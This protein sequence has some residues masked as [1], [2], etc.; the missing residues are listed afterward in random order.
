[1]GDATGMSGGAGTGTLGIAGVG[2]IGG[3]IAAAVKAR[4]TFGRVIGFG[5][6]VDRLEAAK[7]AGLIDDFD[8]GYERHGG[9]LDLFVSCLPVDRIAGSIREAASRMPRGSLATDAGSVKRPLCEA[10]GVEPAAGVTFVGS[11]PLAGSE[12]Q[13][14]EH[15]DAGLFLG[16]TC[17][18]T[19]CGSEP[20]GAV[21]RVAEFWRSIGGEVTFLPPDE[22][23]AILARTSH[24]PHVA[25]AAVA[26]GMADGHV[27]F[28]AGGFRDTTRIASGDPDLW[29]GIL[30][31][32]RDAVC[33]ALGE[34]V[35]RCEAIR[36]SLDRRDAD[37]LREMLA[38]AKAR[39]ERFAE[40]FK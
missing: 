28:A 14:F 40:T 4:G 10:V 1:M 33:D 16:R 39:R 18:L 20:A 11:H 32:N 27:R 37:S 26:A 3:S 17:V 31:A 38:E 23:D 35:G 24:L 21:D 2:L 8:V 36:R 12:R 13:G 30:L 6:S 15:A 19:P 7:R 9:R 29:T 34:F 22:H 5:R 25:A